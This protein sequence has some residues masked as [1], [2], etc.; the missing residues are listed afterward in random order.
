MGVE[1]NDGKNN[2]LKLWLCQLIFLECSK[3]RKKIWL[4]YLVGKKKEE[5]K[6]KERREK[7]RGL[8][9]GD[10]SYGKLI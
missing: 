8:G 5:G 7:K 4:D 1:I 6:K 9:C 10:L 3:R 2:I